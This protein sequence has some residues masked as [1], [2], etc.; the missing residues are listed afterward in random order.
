MFHIIIVK[1]GYQHAQEKLTIQVVHINYVKCIQL[2]LELHILNL[3]VKHIY[4]VVN[5]IVQMEYVLKRLVQ[6]SQ[7]Q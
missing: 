1:H 2:L 7:I 3:I 6:I 4:Q 5:M